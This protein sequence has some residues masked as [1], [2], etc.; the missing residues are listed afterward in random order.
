MAQRT[1]LYCCFSVEIQSRTVPNG[2]GRGHSPIHW[3][4]LHNTANIAGHDLCSESR[5]IPPSPRK[6]SFASRFSLA[7][8]KQIGLGHLRL[9]HH[10]LW[11]I[12][13]RRYRFLLRH[14]RLAGYYQTYNAYGASVPC[15]ASDKDIVVV[16][17]LNVGLYRL[18]PSVCL[19]IKEVEGI[20]DSEIPLTTF[21][22][23][24]NFGAYGR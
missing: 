20:A 24:T 11:T 13:W 23:L 16:T 21:F 22:E 14:S 6:C 3:R 10:W 12:P 15:V 17:G 9:K 7:M 18:K 8:G 19:E 2:H 4:S 5:G 1:Y